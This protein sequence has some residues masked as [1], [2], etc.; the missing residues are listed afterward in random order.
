MAMS[1]S[2]FLPHGEAQKSN[3]VP[4]I[5]SA[6]FYAGLLGVGLSAAIAA[7]SLVCFSKRPERLSFS[8][9]DL[10]SWASRGSALLI[11]TAII[12]LQVT[13]R[14]IPDVIEGEQYFELL[15]WAGGHILQFAYV[16]LAMLSWLVLA[17]ICY[18]SLKLNT[19]Q[20]T[21]VFVLNLLLGF[22]GLYGVLA[23]DVA[24]MDFRQF[25]TYHMISAGSAAPLILLMI[26]ALQWNKRGALQPARKYVL[27][28]L[29]C[30]V[31]LFLYGGALGLQIGGQDTTIPAHY[32][33]AIVAVTIALMGFAYAILP[34]LGYEESHFP[35][36]WMHWQPKI[37]AI[38]QILHITGLAI[39]GGYGA[40]RKTAGALQGGMDVKIAMGML[41]LGGLLAI[42]GGLMFVFIMAKIML[43][44]RA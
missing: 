33:G 3:Y 15:F 40:L 23:Y 35:K 5:E 6:V 24:S 20:L 36:K 34:A 13:W 38:G 10:M 18:P 22:L 31:L 41:G 39:S 12:A 11:L 17:V 1:I 2:P 30:S 29:L 19:Q 26:L 21:W 16:Q 32:H 25:Y 28:S 37:Y 44:R 4:V 42:I 14:G 43:T 27:P 7:V 9:N 8:W